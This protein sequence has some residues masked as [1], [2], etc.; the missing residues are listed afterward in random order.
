MFLYGVFR[1][2]QLIGYLLV[3]EAFIDELQD[4]QFS[5]ADTRFFEL[6]FVDGGMIDDDLF[7]YNTWFGPIQASA[8]EYADGQKGYAENADPDLDAIAVQEMGKLR[9]FKKYQQR[10][11]DQPK[12]DNYLFHNNQSGNYNKKR[13]HKYEVSIIQMVDT[14]CP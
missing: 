8:E 14:T 10:Q 9:H 6:F 11:D 12:T 5:F 13:P 2:I 1:Q 4:F 7:F 3:A